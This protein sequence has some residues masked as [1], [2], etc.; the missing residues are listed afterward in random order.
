[1]LKYEYRIL[2]SSYK[3]EPVR[4]QVWDR[5]PHAEAE[6]ASITLVKASPDVSKDGLYQRECRPN[7]L[8]RWDLDV[9]PNKTG[10]NA[11]AINYEFQLALDRNMV[12]NSLLPSDQGF[13]PP[14]AKKA[15]P[16][17]APKAP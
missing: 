12:I 3:K 10:E 14:A 16:I 13:L 4:V 2:V 17:P 7:N 1:V 5:L 11:V 8:L 9:A 6:A 15:I